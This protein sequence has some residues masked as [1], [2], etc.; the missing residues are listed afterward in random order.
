MDKMLSVQITKNY[1]EFSLHATIDVM[2][3]EFFSLVGPS[4][5]GKTTLL[6]LIAGLER[7]D[8]GEI[9]LN[10]KE[11]TH[12]PPAKRRIGLVFQDLALFPHLTVTGN[13]EYGLKVKRLSPVQRKKRVAELLHLF[14]LEQLAGR[15]V[16][17]L[18]GGERQRVALA[19]A[20]SP[21]PHI[22]LMDEPF[23]ALDY[24]LRQRLRRELKDL[25][26]RL[27]L[28]IIFVTHQQEEALSLS[29][30][31]AVMRN[32]RIIQ[33]GTAREVYDNP[34]DPFIAEFLGEANFLPCLVEKR[35][36]HEVRV[37]LE[38]GEFFLITAKDNPPSGKSW[39]VIKP[40]DLRLNP[41][42]PPFF[43]GKIK[44]LE[45]LGFAY[46]LLV[47]VGPQTIRVLTGKNITGLEEGE[48]VKLGFS[49]QA[50]RFFPRNIE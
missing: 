11:I 9:W 26:R 32:G 15:E 48:R 21:Q 24:G 49:Y 20:L 28:T 2:K 50:L 18:S 36:G 40:E 37:V 46:R 41:P 5:C 29:D 30:R 23:S 19:R 25:Q 8:S 16:N 10:G 22:L 43:T 39:L 1:P 33:T 13:I 17:Q 38:N 31:L 34:E 4:G 6:R 12:L 35:K 27:G 45:Y 47:Q 44:H 42:E 14:E 7:P 3:G